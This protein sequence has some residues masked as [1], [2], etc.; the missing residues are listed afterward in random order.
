MIKIIS[1]F[2]KFYQTVIS[3]AILPRCRYLPTCSQYTLEALK[4]HGIK[5]GGFL[6]VK[7]VCSCHPWGN[8]GFDPVPPKK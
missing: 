5:R 8:S 7:R 4:L 1:I 6:S 3:P 2:I